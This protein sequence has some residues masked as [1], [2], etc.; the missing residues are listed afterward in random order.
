MHGRAYVNG[1]FV[2]PRVKYCHWLD[3]V[4]GLFEV[5][6]RGGETVVLTDGAGHISEGPGFKV[7]AVSG[8]RIVTPA[9][10][11]LERI[12]RRTAI[13]LASAAGLAVEQ[14][15]LPVAELCAADEVFLSSTGGGVIPVAQIDGV[16]ACGRAPGGKSGP[17]G[18]SLQAA[19]RALRENPRYVEAKAHATS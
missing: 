13:E 1:K 11:V 6:E 8:R 14:R 7:P 16:P 3:F 18:T 15:A 4:L 2:D 5:Y 17:I 12:S 19:Y 10:G 9:A